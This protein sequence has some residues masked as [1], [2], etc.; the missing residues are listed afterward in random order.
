M[1]GVVE[2]FLFSILVLGHL[3]DHKGNTWRREI[4]HMYAIEVTLP[5]ET[6]ENFNNNAT[7]QLLYLFPSVHCKPPEQ[8]NTSY[9]QTG[10]I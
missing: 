10:M 8:E 1:I 3:R 7:C 6:K 4:G 9:K 2:S 5:E